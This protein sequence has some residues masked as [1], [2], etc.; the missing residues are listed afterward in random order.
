MA[1][2]KELLAVEWDDNAVET[3]RLNFPNVPVYHGDITKL[4]A[5]DCLGLC[6]IGV[7]ELGVLDGSPPCQGFSTAGKRK[8]D[9][10]RNSLFREYARLLEGMQP[11]A[12]VM[13]NVTG[14]VKGHMKQ[15]YLT[16]IKTLRECGYK[17]RG[18][19][20]NAAHYGVPQSRERVI[21][22]GVRNDLDIE[23]THPKPQ[24]MPQALCEVIPSLV[25]TRSQRINPWIP[26]KNPAATICK[27]HAGYAGLTNTNKCRSLTISEAATIGSFPHSFRFIGSYSDQWARIGNSVPPLLMRAVAT[28]VREHILEAT[29]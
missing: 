7:G 26:S 17:A 20:L 16:I 21:I 28:H 1:G 18:E 10:P 29:A 4:S 24:T 11:R 14:M 5:Q 2:Y 8:Y 22:I 27:T 15:A 25:A 13:E 9:D 12:F 19:V 3:F 6:N 23:P